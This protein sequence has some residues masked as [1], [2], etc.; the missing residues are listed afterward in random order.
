MRDIKLWT[1][2]RQVILEELK[3]SKDH[4]TA[5]DLYERVSKRLPGI[6]PATVFRNLD[7]L[8]SKGLVRVLNHGP[9]KR[10]Y[11]FRTVNHYHIRCIVCDRV[12]DIT[13]EPFPEVEKIV[14]GRTD[15]EVTDYT[16]EFQGICPRCRAELARRDDGR[17]AE[18]E[19]STEAS[20]ERSKE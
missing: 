17:N 19:A 16:L 9:G 5:Y 4:P 11:D 10:H 14:E 7:L 6:S 3:A 1:R 20:E 18:T 15:Y 12:D 2:Q 8:A 13:Y